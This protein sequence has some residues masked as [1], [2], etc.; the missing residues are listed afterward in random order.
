MKKKLGAPK[1]K[2]PRKQITISLIPEEIFEL[3]EIG[4]SRGKAV[5][6]LLKFNRESLKE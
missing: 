5:S 3:D 6:K 1:K 4:P 2:N